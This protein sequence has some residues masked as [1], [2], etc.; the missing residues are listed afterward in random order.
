LFGIYV[1]ILVFVLFYS[2]FVFVLWNFYHGILGFA[3]RRRFNFALVWWFGDCL[4]NGCNDPSI[5]MTGWS[6]YLVLVYIGWLWIDPGIWT[7][8][9]VWTWNFLKEPGIFY[10]SLVISEMV[11]WVWLSMKLE[12][13]ERIWSF[14]ESYW[15]EPGICWKSWNEMVMHWSWFVN[16]W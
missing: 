7:L 1:Y 3:L 6:W 13:S 4:V 8:N 11:W 10:I 15:Y 2:R 16:Y 5:K 9:F 14:L 12:Y